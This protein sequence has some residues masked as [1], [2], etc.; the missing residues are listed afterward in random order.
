MFIVY[1]SLR[2]LSVLLIALSFL[3]INTYTSSAQ[4]L[5]QNGN[6]E[7]E[8]VFVSWDTLI[9][10]CVAGGLSS[11]STALI[12]LIPVIS[13]YASG[14]PTVLTFDLL[15]GWTGLGCAVGIWAGILAIGTA[16]V[17]EG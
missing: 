16:L 8:E 7:V 14:A 17:L 9:V 12:P 2:I 1:R 3:A 4:P 10:G 6:G 5:H 13:T 15:A 11:A